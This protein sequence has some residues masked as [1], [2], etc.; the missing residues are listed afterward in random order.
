MA[1]TIELHSIAAVKETSSQKRGAEPHI[2]RG[3]LILF[4][5]FLFL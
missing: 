4:A 3:N 2:D 5:C 1:N